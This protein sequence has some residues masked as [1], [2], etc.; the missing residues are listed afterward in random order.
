MI[1][2]KCFIQ[3]MFK[4]AVD[5]YLNR[6]NC[7]LYSLSGKQKTFSSLNSRDDGPLRAKM[8]IP[9]TYHLS[10]ITNHR[11]VTKAWTF[12]VP[13]NLCHS[14][15]IDWQEQEKGN[16]D[17]RHCSLCTTHFHT[18]WT[19]TVTYCLQIRCQNVVNTVYFVTSN[20][21]AAHVVHRQLSGWLLISHPWKGGVYFRKKDKTLFKIVIFQN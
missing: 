13:L 16:T 17:T 1:W 2:M 11:I 5:T 10:C 19:V 8:P 18:W 4:G 15:V 3:W 6:I 7:C 12:I 20:L 14:V 9:G 21:S